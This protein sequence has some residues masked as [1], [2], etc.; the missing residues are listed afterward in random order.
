MFFVSSRC[1]ASAFRIEAGIEAGLNSGL[2]SGLWCGLCSGD[3]VFRL[4]L[5]FVQPS[6]GSPGAPLVPRGGGLIS[7]PSLPAAA[8]HGSLPTEGPG[9][10]LNEGPRP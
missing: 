6:A 8:P 1:V 7:P 3:L 5:G 9:E 10:T 2:N 4:V